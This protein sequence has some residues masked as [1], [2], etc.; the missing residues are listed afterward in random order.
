MS[1]R[2][3]NADGPEDIDAR[4]AEIIAGLERDEPMARWPD[5]EDP[6]TSDRTLAQT[7]PQQG[8]EPP[9]PAG[10]R[11]WAPS[12]EEDEGHFEPPE[13]PPLPI[14]KLSTLGGIA[15]IAVGILILLMP[16]LAG[17]FASATIPLG[18]VA[19]TGGLAWLLFGLRKAGPGTDEDD[20]AQL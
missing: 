17:A 19:I 10:P 7:Q 9:E 11:D 13:P 15:A 5:E 14:P 1:T 8:Q 6:P 20:G 2:R 18:M 4:F 12:E 16:Q 3:D